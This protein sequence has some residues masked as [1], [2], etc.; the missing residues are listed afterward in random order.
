MKGKSL[1]LLSHSLFLFC[2]KKP[3]QPST[4]FLWQFCSELITEKKTA[5]SSHKLLY[6]GPNLPSLGVT[7]KTVL[8]LFPMPRLPRLSAAEMEVAFC[9]I[10]ICLFSLL[11]FPARIDCFQ[12]SSSN[13]S[14]LS[15]VNSPSRKM[16]FNAMLN[17]NSE[18]SDW[19]FLANLCSWSK[20]ECSSEAKRDL[21]IQHL[22]DAF[23]CYPTFSSELLTT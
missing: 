23:S 17:A 11:I 19:V 16:V 14:S 8:S 10:S 20:T 12:K 22:S 5:K 3:S 15:P 9:I 18:F 13:Y 21:A 6:A 1:P 2:L 4:A 7:D